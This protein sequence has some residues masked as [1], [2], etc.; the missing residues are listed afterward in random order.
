MLR[1]T[2]RPNNRKTYVLPCFGCSRWNH[3]PAQSS[4]DSRLV[5]G[6]MKCPWLVGSTPVE[7]AGFAGVFALTCI[8]CQSSTQSYWSGTQ[9]MSIGSQCTLIGTARHRGDFLGNAYDHLLF[10]DN[11]PASAAFDESMAEGNLHRSVGW[12]D[13]ARP[14]TKR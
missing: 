12:V 3:A 8:S 1:P 13:D 14:N 10:E 2:A 11:L 6:G 9:S 7:S 5:R 4:C